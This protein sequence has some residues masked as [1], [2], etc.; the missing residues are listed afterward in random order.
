MHQIITHTETRIIPESDNY[1]KGLA[2]ENYIIDLFNKRFF[3][4]LKHRKSEK[5]DF[6]DADLCNPDF[7]LELVFSN[8]R[9]Y[10]FSVECKWRQEFND[11][12]M[13]RWAERYQINNYLSF[14]RRMNIPVF[15]AIGVGGVPSDPEHLFVTPLDYISQY[16]EVYES[17][18]MPFRRSTTHRLYYNYSQLALF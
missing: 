10:K 7:D 8:R 16:C 12:N 9:K 11:N 6:F 3:F 14:Q 1:Q 15:V 18:L 5:R 4:Q 2:F 13:I 17:Y